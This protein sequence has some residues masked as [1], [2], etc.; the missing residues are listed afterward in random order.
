MQLIT[1]SST[2][3]ESK[4]T[5]SPLLFD[6]HV[7]ERSLAQVLRVYLAN[8]RQ[9]TSKTKSRGEVSRTKKKLYKQKGTGGARHGARSAPI[10]VGGGVAHGP[11]GLENWSLKLSKKQ[12]KQ[13]LSAALSLQIE[14]IRVAEG[15]E[16]T[17]TST[18]AAAELLK[19]L[20]AEKGTTLI[21]TSDHDHLFIRV[22]NN[23]Q[24]V[25]CQTANAVT[26]REIL[27]ANRIIVTQASL[28]ALELRIT[29][30]AQKVVISEPAHEEKK[31][32]EPVVKKVA[33]PK[34]TAVTKK[35][36]P[37]KKSPAKVSTKKKTE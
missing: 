26:A 1:V 5:A 20:R 8:E 24:G 25:S 3:S 35:V 4:M 10:F 29:K 17:P 11:K 22:V 33:A 7:N 32:E 21:I 16:K 2:G 12:R 37:V 34:K 31:E 9:A 23:I 28:E 36:A 27:L 14:I 6:E 19:S 18:K 30:P 13:A 15:F